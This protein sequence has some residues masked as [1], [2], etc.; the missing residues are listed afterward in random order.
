MKLNNKGFAISSIMYIILVLAVILIALTLAI[1]S[2]RKLILD[3][4]KNEALKNIYPPCSLVEGE[5][6]TVGSKYLCKVKDKMEEGFEDGYYFY[7]LS[8]NED[9]TT[10]LIMERNICDDGTVATQDKLCL[11]K[12][13]ASSKSNSYGPVTALE[14]VHEATKGWSNIPNIIIDYKDENKGYYFGKTN[15]YGTIKTTSNTTTITSKAGQETLKLENLKARLPMYSEVYGSG[16]CL[17]YGDSGKYGVC[18]LWLV[19]YMDDT[20]YDKYSVT[21]G[22]VNIKDLVGY[23]LLSSGS[24][25][26]YMAWQ[27]DYRGIVYYH[28]VNVGN[29]GIRPVITIKL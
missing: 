7:V 10:N 27:V 11:T 18:P 28:D 24:D 22:K 29:D 6:N 16:K 4:L 13:Y 19:N 9:G 14:Y 20:G 17:R 15:G 12:W 25:Q 1:L 5:A 2:S 23:W 3:K 8:H 21:N 26:N